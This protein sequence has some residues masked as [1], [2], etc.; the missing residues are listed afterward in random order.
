MVRHKIIKWGREGPKQ[1]ELMKEG[2]SDA[3]FYIKNT[4]ENNHVRGV[5]HKIIKWG[6]GGPTN[7]YK[8]GEGGS[9][10]FSGPPLYFF[11]C[12]SPN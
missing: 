3:I 6:R 1:K 9:K 7:N 10:K 2:G 11:K 4:S 12:N 5:Q 8:M